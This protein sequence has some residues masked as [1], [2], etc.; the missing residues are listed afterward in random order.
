MKVRF[1]LP[2][3]MVLWLPVMASA[4]GIPVLDVSNLAQTTLT[5][6][7]EIK[8]TA[9]QVEQYALQLQQYE[10]M[11][12]NTVA[13]AAYLWSEVG[14]MQNKLYDIQSQYSYYKNRGIDQYLQRFGNVNYYRDSENFNLDMF[15]QNRA[16][17]IDSSKQANDALAKTI[18]QQRSDIQEDTA[19]LQRLQM[20]VQGYSGQMEAAQGTNQLLAQQ[21]SQLL[22]LRSVLLTQAQAVNAQMIEEN[23]KK[24]M[25]EAWLDKIT[26]KDPVKTSGY[27]GVRPF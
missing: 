18:D 21:N 20:Q 10:N 14:R 26:G 23:S 1:L 9:K 22:Q 25:E 8:Q 27:R 19:D 3:L 16:E 5:A 24:A 17:A 4:A 12:K 13:P 15:F 6:I 11:V 7:E 2:V